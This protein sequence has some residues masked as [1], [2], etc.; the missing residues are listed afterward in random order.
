LEIYRHGEDFIE[1]APRL[2]ARPNVQVLGHFASVKA[3][4]DLDQPASGHR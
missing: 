4:G 1:L 3:A 2:P